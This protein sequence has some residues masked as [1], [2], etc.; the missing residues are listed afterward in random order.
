MHPAAVQAVLAAAGL[1]GGGE[2]LAVLRAVGGDDELEPE[3]AAV[4]GALGVAHLGAVER[5]GQPALGQSPA[6][7]ADEPV[8]VAAVAAGARAPR[9]TA[10]RG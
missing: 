9:S 8:L 6:F 4:L 1:H 3:Q 2:R 5:R 10:G 7:V